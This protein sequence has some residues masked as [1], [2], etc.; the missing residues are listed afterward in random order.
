MADLLTHVLVAYAI[1]VL[2]SI[3][4]DW[5]SSEYV[6]IAMIGSLVPDLSRMELVISS[7]MMESAFGLSFSWGA[8]H[9]FGGSLIAIALG[10]LLVPARIR[11]RVFA[12]LLVGVLSHHALDIVLMTPSGFTYDVLWPLTEHRPQA[13]DLYLSSDQ[14]PVLIAFVLAGGARY[15]IGVNGSE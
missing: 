12:L 6:T 7:G 14:W 5:I 2:L 15:V 1:G 10:T 4:Y 11:R 8:F 3:R 9:T 13:P